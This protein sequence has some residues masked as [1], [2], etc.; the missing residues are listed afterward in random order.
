MEMEEIFINLADPM[1]G[2]KGTWEEWSWTV[3]RNIGG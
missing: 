1:I 3:P 2:N